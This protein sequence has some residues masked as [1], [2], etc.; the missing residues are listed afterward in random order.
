MHVMTRRNVRKQGWVFPLFSPDSND[1]LS[2]NFHR[3]VILYTSC[4]TRSV[5]FGQHCLPKVST[6]FKTSSNIWGFGSSFNTFTF[7]YR[8][9]P[10]C[11]D[12]RLLPTSKHQQMLQTYKEQPQN[13]SEY[14]FIHFKT[15]KQFLFKLFTIQSV[16]HALQSQ[17]WWTMGSSCLK[18][19]PGQ[20]L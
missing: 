6:G 17:S 4:D 11:R 14:I 20:R 13:Y 2:L 8:I 16:C 9:C 5:G 7:V 12:E 15:T 3:F 19:P 1:R 10:F 18:T